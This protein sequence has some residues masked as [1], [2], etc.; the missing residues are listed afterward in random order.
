MSTASHC[1]LSFKGLFAT[2]E[3][4]SGDTLIDVPVRNLLGG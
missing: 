1:P 2:D 3:V 4:L